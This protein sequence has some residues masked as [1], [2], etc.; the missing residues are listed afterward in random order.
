MGRGLHQ[1]SVEIINATIAVLEEIHPTTVRSICYQL[2]VRGLIANMGKNE[3]AKVSRLLTW[4]REHEKIPWGWIVDETR[5]VEQAAQW[6][7]GEHF[8]D[9][10]MGQY[11]KNYWQ[12]Q[13]HHVEVISEKGTVRGVLASVLDEFGVPFRVMHGFASATA[14]NDIASAIDCREKPTV[15]LYAGDWDP[16]GL[17]MSEVDL[18]ER[19]KRYGADPEH[20]ELRRIALTQSDV[21]L[22]TLPYFQAESKK[23]DARHAWFT[24]RYGEK[25]W[26]LD[27]MNPNDLRRRVRDSIIEYLDIDAWNHM[28]GVE[29]A[30]R[31]S[32]E[33]VMGEWKRMLAGP[34]A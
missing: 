26:E 12:E 28:V 30:E 13:E 11:R 34:R 20:F 25:C 31:D 27:A 2:F 4:A 23:D 19:L 9:S 7:D 3:T 18:P 17:Y 5:E 14:T 10:V 32:M 21:D 22:G 16:S 1:Q 33:L 6:H 8:I 24:S 29:R 15:L